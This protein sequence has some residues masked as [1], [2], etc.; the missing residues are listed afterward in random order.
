LSAAARIDCD[1]SFSSIFYPVIT[2][3]PN[4]HRPNARMTSAALATVPV[5]V[6]GPM[7]QPISRSNRYLHDAVVSLQHQLVAVFTYAHTPTYVWLLCLLLTFTIHRWYT[8][9]AYKLQQSTKC[10]LY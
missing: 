7:C 8:A 10:H 4:E 3:Q 9:V 1:N 6:G 5:V 2:R